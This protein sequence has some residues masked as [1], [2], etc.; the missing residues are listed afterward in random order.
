MN[1]RTRLGLLALS[2]LIASVAA[3]EDWPQWRGPNRNGVAVSSTALADAWPKAGPRKL[4]ESEKIPS[5][6][7]GGFSC[8]SVADGRAYVYVNR[9]IKVPIETRTVSDNVL[10]QLGWPP[11]KPPAEVVE[12][13]EKARVSEDRAKLKG[14]PLNEWVNQWPK[15]H[16]KPDELKRYSRF[17]RDRLKRGRGAT[18]LE[19]LD[20]L[21]TIRR[22]TFATAGELD[23]WLDENEI[24]Q[25]VRKQ[26]L[27]RVPTTKDVATDVILCFDVA[28]GKTLWKKEYPGRPFGWGS[29]S[30][31]NIHDGRCYVAGVNGNIYC[32]DATDGKEIWTAKTPG[33]P[34]HE[35]NSSI[36]ILGDK[37]IV[38]CGKLAALSVK[39]GKVLWNQ[40]VVNGR[41]SS[42]S[43]WRSGEA[44]Y[45]ICNG[46][47]NKIACV[48]S[49]D[50]KVVWTVP[51]GNS[52]S[53]VVSGDT[54]VVLGNNKTVGLTAYKM[55]PKE[56]TK[57]WTLEYWDR[58]ASPLIYDGHVYVVCNSNGGR[59]ACIALDTGK[60]VWD[61]KIGGTEFSSPVA[62]DGKILAVTAN[63]RLIMMLKPAPGEYK[64]LGQAK[65]PI[66]QCNSPAVA[67]GKLF[68]RLNHAVACYDLVN[69][70]TDP[71]KKAAPGK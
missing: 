49:A 55:T 66:E 19:L 10:R 26:F 61:Q 65:L 8:V 1:Y 15:D 57:L 35:V 48:D 14:K 11:K 33:N 27:R 12:A 50:G 34:G 6:G 60:V 45:L 59:V 9:K 63:G 36:M 70:G 22:K 39:D 69:P 20:K 28:D 42:P 53:A 17:A 43:L 2:V 40:P 37:L 51:G 54:V 24:P 68:L 3:A 71:P 7:N 52:S 31:P 16:L 23:K 30:T 47:R 64:V 32:L 5:R 38:M 29:S 41:N 13:V 46:A 21:A 62:V 4:W 58:G 56:A 67:D 25:P 44:T 18:S